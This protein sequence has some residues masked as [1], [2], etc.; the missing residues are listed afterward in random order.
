[1]GLFDDVLEN[2]GEPYT[3]GGKGFAYGTHEVLIDAVGSAQKK[4]RNN[5][6]A[7]VIEVEVVG[8]EDTDRKATATLYFHTEG[9]A[10]M[11]ITKILG[12]LVHNSGEDKKDTI[13][14]L[15]KKLFGS[16]NDP[17]EAR[18]VAVKLLQQK[19]IAKKAYLFADPQGKYPTTSYGDIWHYA[20]EDP[21]A[22]DRAEANAA[23]SE[24]E[25]VAKDMGGTVDN[26]LELP[27]D[28]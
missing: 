27:D 5:P 23:A 25:K 18:D 17:T 7:A 1:M 28:L 10:K 11:S 16:I 8:A 24:A 2:V 15:G 19:M 3:G 9:G 13:R 4:T 26:D 6:D 21:N 20:Y 14:E 12:I 22:D